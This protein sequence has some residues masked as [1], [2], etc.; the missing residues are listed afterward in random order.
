MSSKI[1][2]GVEVHV[3]TFYQSEYSRPE[4]H[5][6]V[7]A[8]RITL[9]NLNDFPVR[10]LRRKWHILDSDGEMRDVEGEGVVGVQPLIEAGCSYQY[11]SACNLKTEIGKMHGN[12][13]LENVTNKKM[14]TVAIPA[15]I[16]EAPMKLN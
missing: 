6:F 8:Y 12:Y 3:E 10:L 7:F 13:I 9:H 16:M 2:N 5:E 1:S 15:F 11:I 4:Q 14:F